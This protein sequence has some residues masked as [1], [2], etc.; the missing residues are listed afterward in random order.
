MPTP[1]ARAGTIRHLTLVALCAA[2]P[3]LPCLGNDFVNWDDPAYITHNPVLRMSPIQVIREAF[4][5]TFASCYAPLPVVSHAVEYRLWGVHP[6]G[7]HAVNILLHVAAALLVWILLARLATP[8]GALAG[9][10]LFAVH[11]LRVEA[12]AWA[13]QRKE[14]LSTVCALGAILAYLR[15]RNSSG[16]LRRHLPL[17]LGIAALLSKPTAVTLPALMLLVDPDIADDPRAA[18]RRILPVSAAALAIALLTVATQHEAIRNAPPLPAMLR[19]GLALRNSA[20]YLGKTV[21]PV[22]LSAV[23]PYPDTRELVWWTLAAAPA[24]WALL[25]AARYRTIVS[26]GLLWWCIALLPTL[27]IIPAGTSSA[28]DRYTYLPAVGLSLA[29]AGTIARRRLRPLVPTVV[30]AAVVAVLGLLSAERCLVWRDSISLWSD[31]LRRYPT[32]TTARNNRASA[33]LAAQRIPEALEDLDAGLSRE[34]DNAMMLVNRGIARSLAGDTD[35]A[36]RDLERA[37]T[38]APGSS[39]AWHNYSR[40]LERA[41]RSGEAAR[42]RARTRN[43][44]RF[45]E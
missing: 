44:G 25:R 45:H 28:A 27:Q 4:S 6:A 30:S 12:V 43:T 33:Y 9:A 39:T 42:A 20:L 1:H 10:L 14:L 29:V 36:L 38:L 17:L 18:I 3:F 22:G 23:Y 37:V 40:A 24:A 31:A 5:A 41:G 34:P 19:P 2:I 32:S 35:G 7:Y 13:S 15:A 21:T 11:P 16:M 8:G 26:Q